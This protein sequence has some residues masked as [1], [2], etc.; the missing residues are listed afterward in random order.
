M[1]NYCVY[2]SHSPLRVWDTKCLCDQYSMIGRIYQIRWRLYKI[3][4]LTTF[5]ETFIYAYTFFNGHGLPV[6]SVLSKTAQ[7]DSNS[8]VFPRILR[9][10][11]W[12]KQ[13][14][15]YVWSKNTQFAFPH[16]FTLLNQHPLDYK[17]ELA[18]TRAGDPGVISRKVNK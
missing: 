8:S 3:T 9:P 7:S 10:H 16:Q 2:L 5:T 11:K 6:V 14:G 13:R 12:T 17:E 1:L 4:E 18:K 15:S